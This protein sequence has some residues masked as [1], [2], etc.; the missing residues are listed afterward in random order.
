[1]S[2][3]AVVL[4]I[5]TLVP[6]AGVVVQAV[7]PEMIQTFHQHIERDHFHSLQD[8]LRIPSL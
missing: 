2:V 5:L 3:V 1:L 8:Q 7:L 6:L 4:T